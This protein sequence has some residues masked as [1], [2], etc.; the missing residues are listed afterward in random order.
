MPPTPRER[1]RAALEA[2]SRKGRPLLQGLL[3]EENPALVDT[4]LLNMIET[5][6]RWEQQRA[7]QG[8]AEEGSLQLP[9]PPGMPMPG[10]GSTGS[11]GSS[12]A[13]QAEES[14][15]SGS[16]GSPG[17]DLEK[18][19]AQEAW[20]DVDR[21]AATETAGTPGASGEVQAE[22]V[23][24]D[25]DERPDAADDQSG[26]AVAEGE[27]AAAEGEEA[28]DAEA[29]HD[30]QAAQAADD[31]AEAA[32][33]DFRRQWAGQAEDARRR[34]AESLPSWDAEAEAAASGP[35][36][37]FEGTWT[38]MKGWQELVTLRKILDRLPELQ[39]LV[40]K[41]GRKADPYAEKRRAPAQR[42]KAKEASG[43]VRSPL[44]PAETSGITRS[45]G[46]LMLLPS[47]LS[48]LAY[49][50][51]KPP[52]PGG[53]GAR[54]L[55]RLR[56]AEA[57]LLSYERS[58]WA[59]E[60]A[61]TLLRQELRPAGDRG[62]LIC[63]LDTSRSMAGRREA[64]A[65]AALLAL[66][67]LAEAQRRPCVLF[68]FSGPGQLRELVVPPPPVEPEAWEGILEF[69]AGTF[70]GGTDLAAPLTEALAYV[71]RGSGEAGA[72]AGVWNCADILL[73]TDGEVAMP[74]EPV[75]EEL[76]RLR[77]LHGL[78]LFALV[79]AEAGAEVTPLQEASLTE[80][81]DETL[82]FEELQRIA[83]RWR[84]AADDS[85]KGRQ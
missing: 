62:P 69:L 42:S 21:E 55:H 13:S 41:M 17:K 2:S 58:A 74:A 83:L 29:T 44:A 67:R 14:E 32:V 15:D 30:P 47:E 12:Q 70:Q 31:A 37:D 84:P 19:E 50:N 43:V 5:V 57:S 76:E 33:A 73:A 48:L 24:Q 22:E 46:S 36:G 38:S 34:E 64:V 80:L 56:R 23:G 16:E 45:D 3:S 77:G 10:S 71:A 81:C 66:L 65:K 27:E 52:R 79:V 63:C 28:A 51:C 1:K 20:A 11:A 35:E 8:E 72:G 61:I 6:E 85:A 54:T 40:R 25:G 49:A 82:R 78:R 39:D 26:D 4:V 59:E 18:A 60:A 53:A 7:P 68:A 9:M 75:V